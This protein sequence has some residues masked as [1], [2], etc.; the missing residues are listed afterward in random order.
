M[1]HQHQERRIC[2]SIEGTLKTPPKS[3]NE[4]RF[5]NEMVISFRAEPC[6]NKQGEFVITDRDT[7]IHF[8]EPG[9]AGAGVSGPNPSEGKSLS[10]RPRRSD[11]TRAKILDAAEEVFGQ[12]GYHGASVVEITK[13]A[14]VG[15]GTFYLYFPS[16]IDIY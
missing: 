12:R 7:M 5:R 16:K 1:A 2:L 3:G 11:Q 9:Q 8:N 4:P 15:L 14:G 6:I 10:P 13:K